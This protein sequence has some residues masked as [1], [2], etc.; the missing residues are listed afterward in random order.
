[1]ASASNTAGKAASSQSL[2]IQI[3]FMFGEFRKADPQRF[4]RGV[5]DL[6]G[7][8]QPKR[9]GNLIK[10]LLSFMA[11]LARE[12]IIPADAALADHIGAK[13]GKGSPAA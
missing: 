9:Y 10:N 2:A 6:T 8:R 12:R 1:M 7:Q 4:Q 5:I 11:Y 3:G 13:G